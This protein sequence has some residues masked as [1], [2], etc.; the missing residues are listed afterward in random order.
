MENILVLKNYILTSDGVWSEM[1]EMFSILFQGISGVLFEPIAVCAVL[2]LVT[3]AVMY[4]KRHTSL[5]WLIGLSIIFMISWRLVIQIISSRYA[6]ILIYPAVIATAF[7]CF[8]TEWLVKYIPKFPVRWCRFVSY[9]F[10]IGLCLASAGKTLRFNPYA[11]YV[12]R[13]AELIKKDAAGRS[14]PH[15]LTIDQDVRRYSFYTG[16]PSSSISYSGCSIEEYLNQI[17]RSMREGVSDQAEDVYVVLFESLK[18][19]DGYYLQ[20]VP[21]HIKQKLIC[22][23]EFYHNRKKKR[24]SR[25][26][27]YSLKDYFKFSL[28]PAGEGEYPVKNK[29]EYKILFD[30]SY[31]AGHDFYK[32]SA[33]SFLNRPDLKAPD[34]KNFPIGW[35][36]TGTPGYGKLSNAALR[37]CKAS[38]GKAV[39]HLKTKSYITTYTAHMYPAKKWRIIIKLSGKRDS[40]FNFAMHCCNTTRHWCAFPYLPAARIPEDD[41]VYEYSCTIPDGF[42]TPET[43]YIRPT[44]HL[45]QGELFVHSIELYPT[46]K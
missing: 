1:S 24:A 19:P 2:G 31:P 8:Q 27:R 38:S 11:D 25:V 18:H 17:G 10:L 15:V 34:L 21:G 12:I 41:K 28:T 30:K 9:I 29:P 6:T 26:Y 39:F 13:A 5:Y 16:F 36:V 20:K 22:L 46:E 32:N 40:L 4:W 14:H 7:F 42:Y 3:A 23:G 44:I 33:D 43:K 37:L 45:T 35:M